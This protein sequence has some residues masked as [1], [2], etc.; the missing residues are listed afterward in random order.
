M[1]EMRNFSDQSQQRIE[2]PLPNHNVCNIC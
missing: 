2:I 1:E